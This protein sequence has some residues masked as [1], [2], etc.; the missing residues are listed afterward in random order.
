MQEFRNVDDKTAAYILQTRRHFEDLRQVASQIAG[1]LVLSASGANT[2]SPDHP[3]LETAWELYRDAI[4]GVRTAQP[5]ERAGIH[6][7]CLLEAGAA[8][9]VSL[10]AARK[11]LDTDSVL[12]PLRRAYG[13]L[14]KGAEALPGFEMVAFGQGCCAVHHARTES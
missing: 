1:L 12:I 11:S 5:T 2:A 13:H 4:D 8:L 9:G 3:L 14:Q 7:N 6:H 10:A